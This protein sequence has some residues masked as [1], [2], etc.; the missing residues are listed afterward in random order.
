[1]VLSSGAD[2]AGLLL[3]EDEVSDG[4]LVMSHDPCCA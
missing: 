2:E 3:E 1:M 4:Y